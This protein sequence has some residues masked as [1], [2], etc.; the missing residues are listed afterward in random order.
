MIRNYFYFI[1]GL[2]CILFAITHSLSG[3]STV[4]PVLDSA[5]IDP[6]IKVTLTYVWHIIGVEN[7]VFGFVLLYMAFH[8]N[9]SKVKL[10][11]WLLIFILAMRWFIITYFIMSN[12]NG[13]FK[14]LIPDTIAI[15]VVI[16]L[17]SFGIKI[18]D[19]NLNE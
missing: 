2:L 16:T 13:S 14:E 4:L 12:N 19:R 5:E 6:N 15:F 18:K 3:I 17:L 8:K 10:V 1:V 9:R 7:L 11:A